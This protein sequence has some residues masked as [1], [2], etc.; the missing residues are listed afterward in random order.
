MNLKVL[1]QWESGPDQYNVNIDVENSTLVKVLK[2]EYERLDIG[3][4][5]YVVIHNKEKNKMKLFNYSEY[6]YKGNKLENK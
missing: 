4:K 5:V 1:V 2:E 6:Q 3:S